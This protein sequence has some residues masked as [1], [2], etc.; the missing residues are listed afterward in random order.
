MRPTVYLSS[1]NDVSMPSAWRRA[2]AAPKAGTVRRPSWSSAFAFCRLSASNVQFSPKT[3]RNQR[4][5]CQE[6]QMVCCLGAGNSALGP[7]CRAAGAASASVIPASCAPAGRTQGC[8][9][10][11]CHKHF[12]GRDPGCGSNTSSRA[13]PDRQSCCTPHNCDPPARS[14]GR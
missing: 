7:G 6:S 12:F 11:L 5:P 9:A 14:R 8:R 10:V 1:R 13:F 4:F 2:P 3:N